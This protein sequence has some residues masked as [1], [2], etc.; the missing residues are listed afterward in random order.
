MKRLV[1]NISFIV[2]QINNNFYKILIIYKLKK[3]IN[4]IKKKNM[5]SRNISKRDFLPTKTGTTDTSNGISFNISY[6]KTDSKI[7][8][9]YLSSNT[10]KKIPETQRIKYKLTSKER[11]PIDNFLLTEI[12][13]YYS[14]TERK[15]IDRKSF[16]KIEKEKGYKKYNNYHVP[17]LNIIKKHKEIINAKKKNTDIGNYKIRIPKEYE[18]SS[19]Q[20][21]ERETIQ[22]T[23]GT[24]N[25]KKRKK[26]FYV[27][28]IKEESNNNSLS[29]ISFD[30]NISVLL[31]SPKNP[32]NSPIN[33][34]KTNTRISIKS[35][36]SKDRNS[37]KS[38]L[39][40][41]RNSIKSPLSK[42]RNSIKS[43]L[44]KDRNSIKSI[45]HGSILKYPKYYRKAS[46]VV[47]KKLTG[48]IED[49]EQIYLKNINHMKELERRK[50]IE[51]IK[52]REK[53]SRRVHIMLINDLYPIP[54][55]MKSRFD[56]NKYFLYK[57]NNIYFRD[58]IYLTDKN[59][60][61][62]Q[63]QLKYKFENIPKK[64]KKYK[65]KIPHMELDDILNLECL[66]TE[67]NQT[68]ENEQN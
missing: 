44:S 49:I 31:N 42:D 60:F 52:K 17:I 27:G 34:I 51:E 39:S 50:K 33:S 6:N 15:L 64:K 61:S 11:K 55:I 13:S 37:I 14:Q 53:I 10:I 59:N 2:K 9:V 36:L 43:V 45:K 30:D 28:H 19:G 41:D 58:N 20:N 38:P 66:K 40:K 23:N 12:P 63:F 16:L 4:I 67:R 26:R 8:E 47:L 62:E 54:N 29:F 3:I 56:N 21:T 65:I 7:S 32:L 46:V 35:P 48:E 5:R 57:Q 18:L 1:K 68:L 25:Q 22:N 24:N